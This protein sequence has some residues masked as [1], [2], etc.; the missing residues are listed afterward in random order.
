M[1]LV[2]YVLATHC[3][4]PP[5]TYEVYHMRPI[6]CGSAALTL[7][8]SSS[9][10]ARVTAHVRAVDVNVPHPGNIILTR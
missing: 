8:S 3:P 5:I 9:I 1:N 10:R 7:Q 6:V 2:V 4:I